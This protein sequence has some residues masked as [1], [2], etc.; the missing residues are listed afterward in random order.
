MKADQQPK[1]RV[2][3]ECD[4]EFVIEDMVKSLGISKNIQG[5]DCLAFICPRCGKKHISLRFG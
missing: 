4:R 3:L 2:Q 1:I 5:R